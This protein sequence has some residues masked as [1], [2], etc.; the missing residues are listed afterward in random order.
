MIGV[1]ATQASK[2]TRIQLTRPA[3]RQTVWLH[4][5][6]SFMAGP[7]RTH[8]IVVGIDEYEIGTAARLTGPVDDAIRFTQWFLKSGVPAARLHLAVTP[9]PPKADE[10]RSAGVDV[11]S[12]GKADIHRLLTRDLPKWDGDLLWVVWGGHGA[13]DELRRRR[14]YYADSTHADPATLD[15]ESAMAMAASSYIPAFDRQIWVID[16][17]QTH[18]VA[19]RPRWVAGTETFPLGTPEQTRDQDALFAASLGQ[20][21]L[22][23]TA[24]RTGLF[25]AEVLRELEAVDQG[26]WPP[27]ID[28]LTARLREHFTRLR[29]SGVHGQTPTY[30]WYRS[31]HGDEGQLLQS[32][33]APATPTHSARVDLRL[34]GTAAD[35]L[36]MIDEFVRMDTREEILSTLRRSIYAS[37]NR[38]A[39]ARLEA[40]SALRTCSRYSGGLSELV[41][42]VRFFSSDTTRADNFAAAAHRL[43]AAS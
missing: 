13:V 24:A 37:I 31:R 18:G 23:L 26:P 34:L 42:A 27:D 20:P 30:L 15:L 28:A 9:C 36:V 4:A 6:V 19:A 14:L 17:C 29:D 22:N 12:A 7:S 33:P 43:T 32:G 35:A 1:P 2:A 11:R 21:A 10:L 41:E 40:I 16:A 39:N 8:A 25:S 5:M 38:Q 3:D